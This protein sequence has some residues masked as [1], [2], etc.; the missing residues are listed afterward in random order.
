MEIKKR[1]T[2]AAIFWILL[3]VTAFV[4]SATFPFGSWKAPGPGF[5][6][7]ILGLILILLGGALFFQ[8]VTQKDKGDE[9]RVPPLLPHGAPFRRV[10]LTLAILILSVALLPHLGFILTAFFL[11]LLTV[12]AIQP[13]TWRFA[14]FYA[15]VSAL[16]ASV[17]F[18]VLL[19]TQLPR[20]PLGF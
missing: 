12:Q 9:V 19:K 3:G 7:L 14:L 16:S 10:G 20:G 15:L 5:L 4:W 1:E 6:P 2:G 11:I 8:A 17:L 18:Q 13:R